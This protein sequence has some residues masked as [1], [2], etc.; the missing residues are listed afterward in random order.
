MFDALGMGEII[1][2]ATPQH[3]ERRELTVGAAVTAMVR[4]GLGCIHQ[5]LDLV[6]RCFPQQ[7]TSQLLSP[8]VTPDQRNDAA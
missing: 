1:E 6:P 4:N 3:P 5:A 7:P 2:Q 8:R